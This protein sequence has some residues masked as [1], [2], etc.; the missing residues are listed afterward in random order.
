MCALTK[1]IYEKVCSY[2][3][4]KEIWNTLAL[5]IQSPEKLPME[6]LLSTL[7]IH[8]I[9]LNEDEGQRKAFKAKESCE[10]ASKEEGFDK[11]ELSFILRKIHFVWKKK[12]GSRWKNHSR[13]QVA[14]YECK[15]TRYFKFECI[16]LE[17][18]KE[19][20]KKKPFFKKKGHVVTWENL[21]LSSFEEED[22]EV[23]ICLMDNSTSEREADNKEVIFNDLS[24][25]QTIY[26]EL[27]SN[28]STLSIGY[29]DLK[30]KFSKLSKMFGV[31]QKE[32]DLLKKE[33]ENLKKDKT[34]NLSTINTPKVNKQL[35]EE[36]IDLRQSLAKFVNGFENLKK[37]LNHKIHPYDKFDISYD[38]KNN[39]KK[40]KSTSHYLNYGRFGHISYDYREPNNPGRRHQSWYLD[41]GCLC[42]MTRERSMFQDLM[43]KLRGWV[44]FGGNQKDKIV[45]ID[46]I[47]K[48]NILFVEGLKHNLLSVSQLCYNEYNVSFNK[49]ECIKLGH[50]SLRLISKLKKCSLVR[51]LPSLVYMEDLLYD[52]CQKEKQVRGSFE[53]K[54][55]V[56]T[57][58]PL[59]CYTLICLVQPKIPP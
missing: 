40:D 25:L 6:E 48:H 15:K 35:Q 59:G 22:E 10:E 36:V 54:N 12:E 2:K 30:K 8:E 45:Q 33:N 57:S 53:S 21:G 49:G 34:K 46:K 7:K 3:S 52:V 38:K 58:R 32:N 50:A 29:K 18:E 23:T 43:P 4:S 11:D 27:L 19:K 1:A 16:S 14:C 9:E 56:S 26:Q 55:I 41:N 5:G 42:H 13:N 31:L 47:S 44:T 24:H 20:E 37:I 17:K 39:L 28:S 51:E